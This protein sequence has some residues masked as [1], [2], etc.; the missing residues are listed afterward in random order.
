M[1]GELMRVGAGVMHSVARVQGRLLSVRR[2]SGKV[3][4]DL[5]SDDKGGGWGS[6]RLQ[7]GGDDVISYRQSSRPQPE[8]SGGHGVPALICCML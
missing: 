7:G 1:K 6:Y 3:S 2:S 4:K 8:S 5:L